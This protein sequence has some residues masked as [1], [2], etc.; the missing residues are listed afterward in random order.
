LTWELASI[1][2]GANTSQIGKADT[3]LIDEMNP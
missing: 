3:H 1:T 2:V